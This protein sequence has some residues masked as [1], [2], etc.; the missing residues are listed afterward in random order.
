MIFITCPLSPLLS[1][2]P[3]LSSFLPLLSVVSSLLLSLRFLLW[4]F[5][6][7]FCVVAAVVD[8]SAA[9]LLPL[10]AAA[11]AC[12]WLLSCCCVTGAL[13]TDA[14]KLEFWGYVLGRSTEHSGAGPLI[15]SNVCPHWGLVPMKFF[16]WVPKGHQSRKR[17][18]CD[19]R[20]EPCGGQ[21]KWREANRAPTKL[22][23]CRPEDTLGIQSVP[24]RSFEHATTRSAPWSSERTC[25]RKRTSSRSCMR[26]SSGA[27]G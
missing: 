5:L 27:V 2:S 25:R 1:S 16:L 26:A 9:A 23:P 6:S 24:A 15:V 3:P 12:C 19:W 14:G 22:S 11:V 18:Q 13:S 4:L 21:C 17:R 7:L 8:A 10:V 20:C